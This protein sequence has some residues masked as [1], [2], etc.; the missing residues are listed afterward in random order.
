MK[1]RDD[2][3]L[4]N[5]EDMSNLGASTPMMTPGS[6][7]LNQTQRPQLGEILSQVDKAMIE[8]NV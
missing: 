4:V 1:R 3:P 5:A 2:E 8:T 7:K 6:R